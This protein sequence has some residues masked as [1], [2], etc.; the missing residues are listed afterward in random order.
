[1]V[2]DDSVRSLSVGVFVECGQRPPCGTCMS[3]ED[4]SWSPD[5]SVTSRLMMCIFV[6]KS[7]KSYNIIDGGTDRIPPPPPL[8]FRV[9]CMCHGFSNGPSVPTSHIFDMF[10]FYFTTDLSLSRM[11]R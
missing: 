11:I 7:N 9:I 5:Q 6:M 10:V 3:H 1:M 2:Y 8:I 4:F